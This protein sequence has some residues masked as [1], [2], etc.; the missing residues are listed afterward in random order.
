M[1]MDGT[2]STQATQQATLAL[3]PGPGQQGQA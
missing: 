3:G 1:T 2:L